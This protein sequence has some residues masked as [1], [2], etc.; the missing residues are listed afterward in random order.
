MGLM[1]IRVLRYFLAVAREE[2]I[3]RAAESLHITQPS[4]SK[5]LMELEQELGKPLLVR[6]KRKITLTEE[7]VLLRKR[8]EEILALFEK[9]EQELQSDFNEVSGDLYLG[10][11]MSDT[12][13]ATAAALKKEHDNIQFHFYSNNAV[14]IGEKL[15]H[16]T[17]DFAVMLKPIDTVKYDFLVLPDISEWGFLMKSG[18][19]LARYPAITRDLVKDMPLILHQRIG[20]QQDFAHWAQMDLEYLNIA[21]TYNVIQG[22]PTALVE[23]ELGYLLTARNLLPAT[24]DEGFCFR[25]LEPAYP[26]HYALVWKKHATFSRVAEAFLHQLEQEIAFRHDSLS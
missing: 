6:G 25:P 15:E 11:G 1:D 2:N 23:H 9:T 17:L 26:I 18:D 4:L 22:Y 3:T 5:Q 8:A 20:L 14:D 24:L 10:G 7:G 19:A 21:A 16:G 12:V 13:L